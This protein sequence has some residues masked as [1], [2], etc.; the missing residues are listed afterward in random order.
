[1]LRLL[2]LLRAEPF[3]VRFCLPPQLHL[4]PL[5]PCPC[6]SPA[7]VN[8]SASCSA[9]S[10]LWAVSHT[11]PRPLSSPLFCLISA[12]PS[13]LNLNLAFSNR[14]ACSLG[15]LVVCPVVPCHQSHR[16]LMAGATLFRSSTCFSVQS[17][18]YSRHSGKF[19]QVLL[20]NN[21]FTEEKKHPIS[22]LLGCEATYIFLY[23]ALNI[24]LNVS[25]CG[26]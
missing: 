13:G 7:G 15:V 10:E 1:M 9:G 14:S 25:Q 12:Q 26:K 23:L 2:L 16:S 8:A 11:V 21:L 20:L 18:A 24:Y 4:A 6:L 22:C 19:C 5:F 3:S 17:L